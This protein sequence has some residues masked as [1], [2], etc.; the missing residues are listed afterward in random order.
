MPRSFYL[1]QRVSH[2]PG[3][4]A[5]GIFASNPFGYGDIGDY[6][7]D[8]M[9]SAEFEWGAIP[10]S[11]DRFAKAGGKGLDVAEHTYNGHV[12]DFLWIKKNGE[13]FDD[14]ERWAEGRPK[15]SYGGE[16]QERPFYGKERPFELEARLNGEAPP[17]HSGEW[18]TALYWA[19][20]DN[21]MWGFKEDGHMERF[22]QGLMD[23]PV[24]RLRG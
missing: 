14:F 8:Y 9:G 7:L 21:V 13:P 2:R 15:D 5:R 6:E 10:E 1:V 20:D 18:R 12:L 23:K 22:L 19:L 24:V 4:P 17:A 16:Y 3:R 11:W